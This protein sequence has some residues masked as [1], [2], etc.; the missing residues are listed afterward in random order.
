MTIKVRFFASL[1]ESIGSGE[2][3]IDSQDAMSASQI[4]T[5]CTQQTELPTNILIAIN[6]EYVKPD[7]VAKSGDEVA[8][9]P[10]VTGG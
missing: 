8:F 10:P 7:T 4:W 1:R 3:I 6:Q 2:K 9:F 5:L